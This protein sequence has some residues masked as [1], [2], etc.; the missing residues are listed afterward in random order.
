MVVVILVVAE[1]TTIETVVTVTEE[2][3]SFSNLLYYKN[4]P[5][6]RMVFFIVNN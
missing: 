5:I 6:F 4:H 2:D 3:T 1:A